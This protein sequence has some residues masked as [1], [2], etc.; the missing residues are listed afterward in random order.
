MTSEGRCLAHAGARRVALMS[1]RS[2]YAERLLA[3]TKRVEFRRRG[4]KEDIDQILVYATMPVG[5]LVGV[6]E[7]VRTERAAPEVLWNAF[8]GVS[9]IEEDAFFRYFE[10]VDVGDALVIGRVWRLKFPVA[11]PAAGLSPRA[12]HSFC[13]VDSDLPERLLG[14]QA[15][16]L[17]SRRAPPG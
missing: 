3:G 10:G 2:E 7:V 12:P 16:A 1:I 13:Y 8:R 11:L 15:G 17:T 5:A 9:G 6:L 14:E 4:P